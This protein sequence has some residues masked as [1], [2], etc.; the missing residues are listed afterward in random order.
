[1]ILLR[2]S[3]MTMLTVLL[4]GSGK[5]VSRDQQRPILLHFFVMRGPG[6]PRIVTVQ[7]LMPDR[8]PVHQSW[9]PYPC[10]RWHPRKPIF[11]AVSDLGLGFTTYDARRRKFGR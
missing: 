1:M 7:V 10:A 5:P 4:L 8:R 11:V 9:Y 6:T 2:T 3:V